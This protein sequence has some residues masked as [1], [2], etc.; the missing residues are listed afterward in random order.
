MLLEG[1]DAIFAQAVDEAGEHL[2]CRPGCTKCCIG[3]FPVTRLDVHRLR[4]GLVELEASDP[5][6]RRAIVRRAREAMAILRDDFPGD[7]DSGRLAD[8]EAE[9]DRFFSRHAALPCHALDPATGRCDLYAYRPVTCRTFG[10]PA[11]FG[12]EKA[13]PCDLC[14]TDA[15]PEQ[16][17]RCRIEPDCEGLEDA[18][19]S[20]LACEEGDGGAEY[21]TIIAFALASRKRRNPARGGTG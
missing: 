19:L 8:D 11:R 16:I 17:E 3:P 5:S 9:I 1:L 7:P 12:D 2:V 4:H 15:D 13:P 21:E 10:P 18:I 6:R 20:R 14:F